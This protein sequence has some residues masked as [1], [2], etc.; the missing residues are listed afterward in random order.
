MSEAEGLVIRTQTLNA[1]IITAASKLKI[2]SRH[3]V[4]Y[5]NIDKAA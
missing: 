5:D 4:G 2:V 1:E 3:G